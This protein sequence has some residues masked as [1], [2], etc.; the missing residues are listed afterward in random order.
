[1]RFVRKGVVVLAAIITAAAA[2][3][4]PTAIT[5]AVGEAEPGISPDAQLAADPI[6]HYIVVLGARMEPRGGPPPIL[7]ER[8]D[9]AAALAHTHPLNR[10]IV[11]GGN[12]WTLPISEATFMH[13]Q[14]VERGVAPWL[15]IDE[16]TAM[17]TNENAI[18]V[19]AML[20]GLRATGAVIVTNG[21]HMPR[22]MRAFRTQVA[23]QDAALSIEPAYA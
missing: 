23:E 8:L 15:V 12:T 6:G 11:T 7:Q 14:L 18:R 10:V 3:L 20:K 9:L 22:A 19:V 21:F 16:H 1:M 2:L 4:V 13:L 5:P 17:S